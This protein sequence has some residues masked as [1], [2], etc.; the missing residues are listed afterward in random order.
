MNWQAKANGLKAKKVGNKV[1]LMINIISAAI[2]ID[3]LIRLRIIEIITF[4]QMRELLPMFFGVMAGVTA[5]CIFAYV[6]AIRYLD[7]NGEGSEQGT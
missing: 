1:L 2:L 4:E 5:V 3:A 7:D 6:L